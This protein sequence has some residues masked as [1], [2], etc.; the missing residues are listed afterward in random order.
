[1]RYVYVDGYDVTSDL[2]SIPVIDI[3]IP[4]Y[5]DLDSQIMNDVVELTFPDSYELFFNNGRNINK[6]AV[7][8]YEDSKLIFDGFVDTIE[9]QLQSSILAVKSKTTIL[10]NSTLNEDYVIAEAY[11]ADIIKQLAG[12]IDIP[13]NSFSYS[14]TLNYHKALDIKFTVIDVDLNYAEVLQKLAEVTCGKIYMLNNELQYEVFSNELSY[15][16]LELTN[17]DFVNYPVITQ[18]SA[19]STVF[20]SIDVKYGNGLFLYGNDTATKVIDMSNDSIVRTTSIIT[21]LHIAQSYQA[22]GTSKKYVLNAT[23]REKL[24]NI[25]YDFNRIKFDNRIYE[26]INLNHELNNDIK[27][28]AESLEGV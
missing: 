23:I 25:M 13:F 6:I 7:Q 5:G 17:R 18:Q 3:N 8:I 27:I 28:I 9:H 20:D 16:V 1:M 24:K 22:L 21:A 2:D 12:L 4:E 26:I 10:F 14:T 15:P 11:P 19:F